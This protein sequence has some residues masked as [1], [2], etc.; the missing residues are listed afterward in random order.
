MSN[1]TP[2]CEKIVCDLY[3]EIEITLEREISRMPESDYAILCAKYP[4][5]DPEQ[6]GLDIGSLMNDM[7]W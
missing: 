2:E 4:S 5:D 6:N 7:Y 1:R 3:A